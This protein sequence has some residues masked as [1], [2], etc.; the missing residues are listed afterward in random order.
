MLAIAR[1]SLSGATIRAIAMA[2]A[3]EARLGD[4]AMLAD[5]S[6]SASTGRPSTVDGR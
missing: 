1:S 6:A 4:A 5:V 2:E 3:S